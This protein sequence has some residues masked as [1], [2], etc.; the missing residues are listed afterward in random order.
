MYILAIIINL[1]DIYL[2]ESD[3]Q[4]VLIKECNWMNINKIILK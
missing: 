1:N 4:K 2:F 3:A